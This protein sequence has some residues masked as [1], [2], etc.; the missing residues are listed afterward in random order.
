MLKYN[1]TQEVVPH[2]AHGHL[3]QQQ[4]HPGTALCLA[5]WGLCSFYYHRAH[6]SPEG[7]LVTDGKLQENLACD[8]QQ[9]LSILGMMEAF[10]VVRLPCVG[11]L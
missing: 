10:W 11:I 1:I 5:L 2:L 8:K 6:L 9:H 3:K 4:Q 7:L